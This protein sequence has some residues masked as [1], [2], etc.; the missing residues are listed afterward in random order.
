[1]IAPDYAAVYSRDVRVDVEADDQ[2][3]EL[4]AEP[5]D[6]SAKFGALL[7]DRLVQVD[8]GPSID[9]GFVQSYFVWANTRLPLIHRQLASGTSPQHLRGLTEINFHRLNAMMLAMWEPVYRPENFGSQRKYLGT[10]PTMQ[11]ALAICGVQNVIMR[12]RT[13]SP[14]ADFAYFKPE[15]E[16]IRSVIEG[17]GNEFDAAIVLLEFIRRLQKKDTPHRDL[18]VVPA[19]M[20]F[21]NQ[22]GGDNGRNRNANFIVYSRDGQA[23]GV[24]VGSSVSSED[25]KRYDSSRIILVDGRIDLGNQRAVRTATRSSSKS[26]QTWSGIVAAQRVS[27]FSTY[28]QRG[29]QLAATGLREHQYLS[30]RRSARH[31]LEGVR[32]RTDE[33]VRIVGER[34]LKNL[35]G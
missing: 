23:V 26:I 8:N 33:A 5:R 29:R 15:N 35:Y 28:G 13:A 27:N 22:R 1:M 17:N 19:P 14:Q 10:I 6:Y 12:Y 34:I 30:L 16:G 31:V 7:M 2:F 9:P 11:D 32:P 3:A 20:Q 18:T 21:S 24:Q 25:R 4:M